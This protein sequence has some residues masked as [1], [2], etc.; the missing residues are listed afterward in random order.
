MQYRVTAL[1]NGLRPISITVSAATP[2]AAMSDLQAQ[3]YTV[4]NVRSN[5]WAINWKYEKSTFSTLI[6]SRELL[7]LLNAGLSLMESLDALSDRTKDQQFVLKILKSLHQGISFSEAISKYPRN[8]PALYTA[9]IRASERTGDLPTALQRYIDYQEQMDRLRK[10]LVSASIYPIILGC[11]GILVVLFLLLY[12]IP[13]F[14]KVYESISGQLPFFSNLLMNLG[15][16]IGNNELTICLVLAVVVIGIISTSQSS[17]LRGRLN[18]YIKNWPLLADKIKLY[19]LSRLYR[20]LG[21]LLRGGIP[22]LRA[23]EMTSGLFGLPMQ[24]AL[25]R[26][27]ALISEGTPISVATEKSGLTTSIAL[28]MLRVGERTGDMGVMME[29]L[30]YFHEEELARWLEDFGKIFEPLLMLFIGLIV[31]AVVVLMYMP[32]FELATAIQ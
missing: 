22:V 16:I 21:M 13:R 19:E 27:S 6:F 26:T 31:G 5:G 28:R 12:V 9:L 4:L 3:G 10:K 25:S 32:I 20:T 23:T 7:A 14:A 18:S 17:Y 2:T 29:R 8:F 24:E 30:A 11:V 1:H 15:Q